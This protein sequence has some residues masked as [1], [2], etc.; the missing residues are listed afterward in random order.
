MERDP[1]VEDPDGRPLDLLPAD[2]GATDGK[3]VARGR[4]PKPRRRPR[5]LQGLT[6][7]PYE[8]DSWGQ[9][10]KEGQEVSDEEVAAYWTDLQSRSV[11]FT[12]ENLQLTFKEE[13][14]DMARQ[15]VSTAGSTIWQF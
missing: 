11:P 14:E 9:W 10:R 3:G 2:D 8:R 4:Q 1:E 5:A 6:R 7:G 12:R 15:E 13:S